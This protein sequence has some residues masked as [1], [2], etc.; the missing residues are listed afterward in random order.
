MVGS[1]DVI[2]LLLCFKA[3]VSGSLRMTVAERHNAIFGLSR[4]VGRLPGVGVSLVPYSYHTC[5]S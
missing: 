5:G 3:H 1:H 4:C 2:L